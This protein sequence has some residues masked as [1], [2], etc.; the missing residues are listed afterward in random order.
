MW[1]LVSI[2]SAAHIWQPLCATHLLDVKTCCVRT[3]LSSINQINILTFIFQSLLCI[4]PIG[5][6]MHARVVHKTISRCTWKN[7]RCSLF[8]DLGSTYTCHR[9]V[10]TEQNGMNS[11]RFLT[12]NEVSWPRCLRWTAIVTPCS[13]RIVFGQNP[14]SPLSKCQ[15]HFANKARD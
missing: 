8:P 10:E 6:M 14:S 1:F 15:N 13:D 7:P 9:I 4:G 12:K 3:L 2:L 11:T 5:Q